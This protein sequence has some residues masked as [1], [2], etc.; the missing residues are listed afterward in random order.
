MLLVRMRSVVFAADHR[1]RHKKPAP[2]VWKKRHNAWTTLN[3][4]VLFLNGTPI[5]DKSILVNCEP[6]CNREDI[7]D[8]AP[9]GKKL[10][11]SS[12]IQVQ[13]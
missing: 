3:D 6:A 4:M 5:R 11:A 2:A 9:C 12:G 13:R 1:T 8:E 7:V 10:S